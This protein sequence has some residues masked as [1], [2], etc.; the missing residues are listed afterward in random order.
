MWAT[1]PVW[2]LDY[3]AS[4]LNRALC[5]FELAIHELD[6]CVSGFEQGDTGRI[7]DQVRTPFP[8]LC[9]LWVGDEGKPHHRALLM[10]ASSQRGGNFVA[11]IMLIASGICN[12][13]PSSRL[14]SA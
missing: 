5:A 3:G 8:E 6:G 12:P 4:N 14:Y 7:L 2:P 1:T 10:T 11:G 9:V 13:A